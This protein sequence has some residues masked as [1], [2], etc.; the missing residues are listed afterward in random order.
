MERS[1]LSSRLLRISP[2]L[3]LLSGT[4][5]RVRAF[6]EL[7]SRIDSWRVQLS[8]V[9]AISSGCIC[10]V[11]SQM[12]SESTKSPMESKSRTVYK[13][14]CLPAKSSSTC[15]R[16]SK[17]ELLNLPFQRH[18]SQVQT[19]QV[20]KRGDF[21]PHNTSSLSFPKPDRFLNPGVFQT[22]P[23]LDTPSN[24]P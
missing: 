12:D 9:S 19:T 8:E 6:D 10:G 1:L 11:L 15:L 14:Q 2:K 23:K 20:W 7:S 18:L 5:Q 3:T 17:I 21:N 16:T 24:Q 4:S 13:L 22:F